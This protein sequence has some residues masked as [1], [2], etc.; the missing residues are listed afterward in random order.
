MDIQ[1]LILNGLMYDREY[2]EKVLPFI[3]EEYFE[4]NVCRH[5]FNVLN[6]NFV[7]Y[8]NPT[9]GE[10]LLVQLDE[11]KKLTQDEYNGAVDICQAAL[12]V[13]ADSD[14][15]WLIDQTEEWCKR[16]ALYNAL[17][18]SVAIFKGDHN[19]G[20]P[21]A[22]PSILSEALG[23]SFNTEIGLDYDNAEEIYQKS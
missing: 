19:K 3:H 1:H 8:D 15:H 4:S 10:A 17:T 16:R 13:S 23:V 18:E 11:S 20:L 2:I 21:D 5:I 22:I 9:P 6:S 7:K 12:S 14:I